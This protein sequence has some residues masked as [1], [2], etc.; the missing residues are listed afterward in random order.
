MKY[1]PTQGK[2]LFA[3]VKS[4]MEARDFSFR[5]WFVTGGLIYA[6]LVRKRTVLQRSG[7]YNV[8]VI[9]ALL[10]GT[11]F[12]WYST[13]QHVYGQSD[14]TRIPAA[15]TPEYLSDSRIDSGSYPCLPV[16]FPERPEDLRRGFQNQDCHG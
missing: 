10:F 12:G 13:K 1:T 7:D 9:S 11:R 2:N 16:F 4:L 8:L 5:E 6:P 15:E 3:A 14:R